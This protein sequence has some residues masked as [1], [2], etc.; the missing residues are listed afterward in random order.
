VDVHQ[1]LLRARRVQ[2]RVAAG[3]HL[4]QA[5]TERDDQVGGGC[6]RQLRV[7]ADA[8]VAGVVRV[9]VVE[10]VLEAE[11][12][13]HRQLPVLGKTLQRGA[14]S[15][16]QPAAAGNDDGALRR[17]QHRAQVAQATWR[18]PGAHRLHAR[19]HRRGRHLRQHV[20]GQRQHHR[21]GTAL[22]RG[23]EGTRHVLGQ[24][25]G[26]LHFGHPLGHA[27]R[28]GAEHLAVVEFLEGFA[29]A[30]V[31]GHLAHEQDQRR[32][33]LE[34]RVHT[35]AGVGGT[36]PAG[37]EADAR[38]AAELA[39]RLGHEGGAAFLP[40]GHEAD[41][42]AV[43]VKAVQHG[44]VAFARH[45]EGGVH[46]LGDQ[47]FHQHMAGAAGRWRRAARPV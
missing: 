45:A 31:A 5:H 20:L 1:L 7:D 42:V 38:P 37:H 33:V 39:L 22:H 25:V 13:A 26:A 3:G 2:Q 30:L 36:R 32:A 46:A 17:Q 34:R 35:D 44:Q 12:A 29:V 8:H 23:V 10:G 43:F 24:A 40:A 4:A 21:P 6:A 11:G 18:G 16:S 14:A 27:Q 28:A 41:A 9:P 15:A 47:G 19:Q